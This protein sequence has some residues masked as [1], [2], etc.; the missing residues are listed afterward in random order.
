MNASTPIRERL[1]SRAEAAEILG[2]RSQ[3]LA[4]WKSAGRYPL[5]VVKVGSRSM[6]RMADI[7]RFIESRTVCTSAGI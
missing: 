3:T 5:P 2:V 7:E 4:V 6:Y 1:L